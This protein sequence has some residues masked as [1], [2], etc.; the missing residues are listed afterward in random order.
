MVAVRMGENHMGNGVQFDSGGL[1]AVGQVLLTVKSGIYQN[2]PL[3]CLNQQ[4]IHRKADSSRIIAISVHFPLQLVCRYG[5]E[6]I[7]GWKM[8]RH[9]TKNDAVKSTDFE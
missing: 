5:R 1:Q 8:F 6:N 4:D 7:A 3:R 2:T 9:I